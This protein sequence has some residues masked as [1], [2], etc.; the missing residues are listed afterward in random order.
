MV[1][2]DEKNALGRKIIKS[3]ITFYNNASETHK[4]SL[5]LVGTAQK[6]RP[7]KSVNLSVWYRE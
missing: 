5:L 4:L 6:P 3:R 2:N 7:L 1:S